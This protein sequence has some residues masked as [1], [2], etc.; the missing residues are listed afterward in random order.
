MG[1]QVQVD[2]IIPAGSLR[3]LEDIAGFVERLAVEDVNDLQVLCKPCHL[4]KGKEDR[5]KLKENEK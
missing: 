3:S 2:H 5:R 4:Q 1:N